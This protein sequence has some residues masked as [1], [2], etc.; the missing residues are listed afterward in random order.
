MTPLVSILIPAYNAESWIAETLSSALAQTHSAIEIIVVN[1][2]SND[3]TLTQARAFVHRG[4][5]IATQSNA[6]ASSARNHALRLARGEFIQFLDAD[7]LLAPD[8]IVRQLAVLG[9][10]PPLALATGCW[11]RFTNDPLT[12]E[13]P[14]EAVYNARTGIEFLQIHYETSSMMQPGAWLAPRPLLDLAG[15]WNESLSLNDD[16]EYF[17]RVML[18]SS[19]LLHVSSAR[20][21]Y[22]TN[23][24]MSLSRRRDQR[25][26]T[27]LYNSVR[28]SVGHLLAADSSERSRAA[29]V[30]AWRG[31]AYE[32]YPDAISLARSARSSAA[33]L[34]GPDTP[35]GGPD[36]VTAIARVFGWSL[37]RRFQ[38]IRNRYQ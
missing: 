20:C 31:L 25:A 35:L 23:H 33:S 8:K 30:R 24:A 6:G 5:R 13:W 4:V 37:A 26:L 34:G 9:N 29:A 28:L 10:S 1:D 22:R 18:Q 36:W 16:G 19:S 21:Y 27:S 17:A 2:G 15:P 12:A 3:D 32:L 11:G 7:D 38:F 14:Q